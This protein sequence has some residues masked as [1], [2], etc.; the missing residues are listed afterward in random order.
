MSPSLEP[1]TQED[2][3]AFPELWARQLDRTPDRLAV[4]SEDAQWTYRELDRQ[5]NAMARE[6]IGHGV[7]HGSRV[8]MCVERSPEAIAAMLGIMKLGAVFVPLD[9]EYPIER[10][11]YM[12]E[13]AA[14][15]T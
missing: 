12:V 8:G 11:R 6:L 15:T 14:I 4:V 2:L 1:Q 5:A 9:P 3:I 13:D 7:R 10:L